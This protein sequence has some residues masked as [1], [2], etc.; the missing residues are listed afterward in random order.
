MKQN[1]SFLMGLLTLVTVFTS[2]M[3]FACDDSAKT[4]I[5]ALTQGFSSELNMN[6]IDAIGS[7]EKVAKNCQSPEAKN[8]AIET[9]ALLLPAD[10]VV[11]TQ[12]IYAIENIAK[13]GSAMP[14]VKAKAITTLSRGCVFHGEPYVK[15]QCNRVMGN[16]ANLK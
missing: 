9:V 2:E 4:S 3:V 14:T 8:Y 16:I 5:N 15:Y 6:K 12:A 10:S 1:L 13:S 11:S 7:V